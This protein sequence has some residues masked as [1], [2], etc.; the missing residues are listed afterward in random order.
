VPPDTIMRLLMKPATGSLKL[1]SIR[2]SC[3]AFRFGETADTATVGATSSRVTL[4]LP[5]G[6]ALSV[7]V[8]V[9]LLSPSL[10]DWQITAILER[11]AGTKPGFDRGCRRCRDAVQWYCQDKQP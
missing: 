2:S 9:K 1:K 5:V 6:T 8:A 10:S 4:R 11:P 3:P 7:A